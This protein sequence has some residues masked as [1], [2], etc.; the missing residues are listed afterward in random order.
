MAKLRVTSDH[1]PIL[2]ESLKVGEGPT[3]FCFEE[4]WILSEDFMEVVKEVWCS[5]VLSGP[6]ARYFPLS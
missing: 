2:L 6:R 4:V 3:P 1:C 5:S